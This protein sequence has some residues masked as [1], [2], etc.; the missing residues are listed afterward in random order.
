MLLGGYTLDISTSNEVKTYFLCLVQGSVSPKFQ[1]WW[2]FLAPLSSH[3]EPHES[4]PTSNLLHPPLP[5]PLETFREKMPGQLARLANCGSSRALHKYTHIICQQD[6]LCHSLLWIWKVTVETQ[7]SIQR[8]TLK[9]T[10]RTLRAAPLQYQAGKS[11]GKEVLL[12]DSEGLKI[13]LF[14][15]DRAQMLGAL[16]IIYPSWHSQY[17]HPTGALV[18]L[19]LKNHFLTVMP[20][21]SH[22]FYVS[23]K[24]WELKISV[25]RIFEELLCA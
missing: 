4:L 19:I 14:L 18:P 22:F 6:A 9:V 3:L 12:A 1:S 23:C 25:E 5:L 24:E 2:P 20:I 16:G 21:L 8:S 10:I 15:N 17:L 11:P 7:P 13:S